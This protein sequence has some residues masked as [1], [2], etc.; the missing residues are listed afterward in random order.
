MN[1]DV[2]SILLLLNTLK[3]KVSL[4]YF[5]EVLDTQSSQILAQS[6]DTKVVGYCMKFRHIFH[7]ILVS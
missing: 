4:I 6:H 1:L 5:F 7:C 2:T 3:K